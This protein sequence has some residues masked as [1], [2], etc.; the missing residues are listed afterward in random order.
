MG[1]SRF[2]V[3]AA[4]LVVFSLLFSACFQIR[5]LSYWPK[6]LTPGGTAKIK[7]NMFPM[8]LDTI[9]DFPETRP[10]ILVG[11]QSDTL[12]RNT[13]SDFDKTA[14]WGGPYS[15]TR[16]NNLRDYLLGD[17]KCGSYGAYASDL[18]SYSS[19]DEWFAYAMDSTIDLSSMTAADFERAFRVNI[20][21]DRAP[22]SDNGAVGQLV[23][24]SGAW[25][26]DGDDVAEGS[27]AVC[28]G[29][30]FMAIPFVSG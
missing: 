25:L 20:Q 7:V 28:T 27:E 21:L 12:V 1:K 11:L 10:F 23:I 5:Y 14:N 8:G 26:D 9:D 2:R 22:G 16:H 30:I 29:V 4:L 6:A 24:F 3:V 13:V 17:M 15:A 19:W 18:A